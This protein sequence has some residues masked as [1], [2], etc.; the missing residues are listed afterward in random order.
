MAGVAG[1]DFIPVLL[2]GDGPNRRP[3]QQQKQSGLTRIWE[4]K[5]FPMSSLQGWKEGVPSSSK[6]EP[7]KWGPLPLAPCEC[8]VMGCR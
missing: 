3:F 4:K 6:S 8:E 2:G 5:D 1:G 7:H